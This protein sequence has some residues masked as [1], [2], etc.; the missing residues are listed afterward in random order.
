MRTRFSSRCTP[1]SNPTPMFSEILEEG[2]GSTPIGD[3]KGQSLAVEENIL[4]L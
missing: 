2:N 1:Y 4:K 3:L